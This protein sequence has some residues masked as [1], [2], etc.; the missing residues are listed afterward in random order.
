MTTATIHETQTRFLTEYEKCG[1][2][3]TAARAVDITL[4]TVRRW[5]R[6]D[7]L[8]FSSRFKAST[9]RKP[10][11]LK[12]AKAIT[13]GLGNPSKMPGKSYGISAKSCGIGVKLQ[14][15]K[16]SV[17]F[18]CYAM[19]G[20]YQRGSVQKAHANRIAGLTRPG[21]VQAMARLINHYCEAEP[22]FRW[23]DSGDIQN[24]EHLGKI[25]EVALRTPNVHH[26][27]PTREYK[28]VKFWLDAYGEFPP[29]L[30]VR[31]SA[32]MVDGDSPNGFGLPTSTVVS[33]HTNTC[34][35]P[36]QDNNCGDCRACWE[37]DTANVSYAV[38]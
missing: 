12:D 35:A 1:T 18:G 14:A 5:R 27:I 26:W 9:A 16:G 20:N 37:S 32:H 4:D 30:T 8:G 34:P 38:H 24:L 6:G 21:W 2:I 10:M 29:N 33:D 36:T 31:L 15:V 23:H 22:Y 11:L 7:K 25:V 13:G 17:C 19:N 28:I 3:K